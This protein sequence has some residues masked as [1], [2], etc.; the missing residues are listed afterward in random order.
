M[1]DAEYDY[2]FRDADPRWQAYYR[3][4]REE[5]RKK[6]PLTNF[7]AWREKLTPESLIRP[8]IMAGCVRVRI[9]CNENC[10]VKDCPVIKHFFYLKKLEAGGHIVTRRQELAH[11]RI[12]Q[13]CATWFLR[14]A[15]APAKEEK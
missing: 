5:Y 15:N 14:W 13:K 7:E 10:P 2:L 3:M 1:T 6:H 4:Q 9:I 8:D 11:R 12:G